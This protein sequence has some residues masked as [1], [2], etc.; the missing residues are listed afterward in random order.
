MQIHTYTRL[1]VEI[2]VDSM[3]CS[4]NHITALPFESLSSTAT[5]VALKLPEQNSP[6]RLGVP[7]VPILPLAGV[8]GGD[9]FVLGGGV[10]LP[11]ARAAKGRGGLDGV[12]CPPVEERLLL[13]G[14]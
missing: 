10:D 6:S 14:I 12:E 11:S 4:D 9:E 1:P 5:T 8:C 7:N 13:L 2:E 3:A